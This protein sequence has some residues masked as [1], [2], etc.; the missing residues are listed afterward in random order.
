MMFYNIRSFN[1]TE[2]DSG[3][4]FITR[5]NMTPSKFA[6]QIKFITYNGVV[7]YVYVDGK[8]VH[9]QSLSLGENFEGY[10]CSSID[11]IF[12]PAEKVIWDFLQDDTV[13]EL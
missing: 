1:V 12:G 9:S 11:E 13:L 5:E 4:Y 2:T 8:P 7:L 10:S 6:A 3:V